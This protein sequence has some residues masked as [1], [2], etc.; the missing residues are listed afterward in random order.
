MVGFVPN[1]D[2]FNTG[3]VV[4]GEREEEEKVYH[5]WRV[6]ASLSYSGQDIRNCVRPDHP[7]PN[8][9]LLRTGQE[10]RSATC[11]G[12]FLHRRLDRLSYYYY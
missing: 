3:N 6:E 10:W 11:Q 4:L 2:Y 9:L 5:D 8:L 12:V 7:P 1:V